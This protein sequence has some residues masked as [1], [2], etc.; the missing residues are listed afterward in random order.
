MWRM[1]VKCILNPLSLP[2]PSLPKIS[3]EGFSR[4]PTSLAFSGVPL[5]EGEAGD[6]GSLRSRSR[7]RWMSLLLG[8]FRALLSSLMLAWCFSRTSSGLSKN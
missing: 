8:S 4:I 2:R 3:L 7:S 1:N 6:E 5:G